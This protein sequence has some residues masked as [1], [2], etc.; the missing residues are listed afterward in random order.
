MNQPTKKEFDCM[1]MKREA[2]ER[3]CDQIKNMTAEQQIEYF[4]N[5]VSSSRFREWWES[6]GSFSGNEGLRTPIG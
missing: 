3:I 5:A 1:A 4:R 2:Q 6:A